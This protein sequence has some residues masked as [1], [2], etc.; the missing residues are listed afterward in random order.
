MAEASAA[1]TFHVICQT[2]NFADSEDEK[3]Q[4]QMSVREDMTISCVIIEVKFEEFSV[5]LSPLLAL[6]E[7]LCIVNG[8][9]VSANQWSCR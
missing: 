1:L 9:D 7:C 6:P 4:F 3:V 2:Q 5:G 8:R